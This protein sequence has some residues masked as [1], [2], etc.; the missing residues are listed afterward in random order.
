M[1]DPVSDGVATR[2]GAPRWLTTS[3]LVLSL[4][5]L[6]VAAYLTVEHYSTSPTYACPQTATVD[7]LKV[8]SSSYAT[9]LGIPVADLG[10]VFF[11]AMTVL[12]LPPAW[13]GDG[14]VGRTAGA[15]RIALASIGVA[16]VLY[17]IWAELFA[18]DAICL[19]CTAVHVIT[20]AIFA[21]LVIGTAAVDRSA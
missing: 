1:S 6:A 17:L 11:A 21:L 20:I 13:R 15:L 9:F 5:G 7:C 16:F 10:L 19:W 4:V 12:T 8:T 14:T 3:T 2:I 18:V